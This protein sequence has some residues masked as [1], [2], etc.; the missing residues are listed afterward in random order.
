MKDFRILLNVNYDGTNY[1]GW[2]TQPNGPSIQSEIENVLSKLAKN[3]NIPIVGCGRTDSGV[4][5]HNYYLHF[6]WVNGDVADLIYKMNKMLPPDISVMRGWHLDFPLHAR[7]DAKKRTYRY[8]ISKEKMPFLDRFRWH[9]PQS[10]DLVLMN[11]ACKHLIGHH[12]FASFAKGHSDVKTTLCHLFQAQ[13]IEN[14]SEYIFEVSANRFLRNMVRSMVGTLIEVG[15]GKISPEDI[16]IIL[17]KKN[18]SEAALSVPAKGLF[19]WEI[20]YDLIPL[21]K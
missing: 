15:L 10:L 5:A 16:Q 9:Y 14:P 21:A 12:D 1:C 2:Q 19:L 3:I 11:K 18:R 6:D 17:S 20:E 8:F 7:F 13:W 4:H